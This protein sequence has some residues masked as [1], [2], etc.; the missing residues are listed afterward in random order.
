MGQFEPIDGKST[1]WAGLWWHPEYNGFC[2]QTISLADLRKFKGAVRLYVRKNK[3][4]NKG[5]NSRPNYC[6]CLRA[7][8]SHPFGSVNEKSEKELEIDDDFEDNSFYQDE[9]GHYFADGERLFTRDEVRKIINGTVADVEY[10]IHDP[11][12]ILPEDFV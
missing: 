10:G 3:F 9:D 11:Y 6:F 7:W 5:E 8:D 1:K 4:F 2:S 12:D